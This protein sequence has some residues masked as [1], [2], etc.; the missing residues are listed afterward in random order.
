[1]DLCGRARSSGSLVPDIVRVESIPVCLRLTRTL[2]TPSMAVSRGPIK[3]IYASDFRRCFDVFW[4]RRTDISEPSRLT[5]NMALCG[6]ER[7]LKK[8]NIF[9]R[10]SVEVYGESVC[11][12]RSGDG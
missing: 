8:R 3:S 5:D 2:R 11:F 6:I 10:Q 7:L 1:M 4:P 12:P 9:D